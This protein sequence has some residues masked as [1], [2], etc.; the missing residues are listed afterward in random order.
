V[1][2]SQL[3]TNRSSLCLPD[4]TVLVI[5]CERAAASR[6]TLHQPGCL[7]IVRAE[8][9]GENGYPSL[10]ILPPLARGLRTFVLL[11]E[12]GGREKKGVREEIF[13]ATRSS[14][15]ALGGDRRGSA[16]PT[17]RRQEPG[18]D[19]CSFNSRYIDE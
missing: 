14:H 4:G 16:V 6:L 7:G 8:G 17:A 13:P 5:L 18:F 12:A 1:V 10:L 9:K 2:L 11:S 19:P 15:I 3:Q